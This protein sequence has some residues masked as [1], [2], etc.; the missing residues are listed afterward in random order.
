M[1]RQKPNA[2]V[3]HVNIDKIL[4]SL[5]N[6]AAQGFPI[7]LRPE[8]AGALR[9]FIFSVRSANYHLSELVRDI[10]KTEAYEGIELET[11]SQIPV[12]TEATEGG[13]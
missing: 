2:P 4:K 5:N 3:E 8:E 1:G 13:R 12:R 11:V 9:L 10:I 6:S 7:T